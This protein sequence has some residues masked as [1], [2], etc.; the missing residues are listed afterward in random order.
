[1]GAVLF[2]FDMTLVDSS[3][4][5]T[6][7]MNG[8]AESRGL[9]L[10]TREEVLSTIGLPIEEAWR[11]LWGRYDPAWTEEYRAR[12]RGVEQSLLRSFPGT[13]SVLRSLRER[14]I[15]T[16]V[17]SN[18]RFAR[19]AVEATGLVPLADVVVGLEDVERPKP[20]PQSVL[21]ALDRL[22]V[23]PEAAAY[24]GDTDIDMATAR[25]A[26]TLGVG[27]TTGAF[28]R[29]GLLAAGASLV[30]DDLRELE[31]ALG[32]ASLEVPRVGS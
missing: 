20:D 16:G 3:H 25:A 21:L 10:L 4:A 8:L 7:C 2:D 18:R 19:V 15:R 17:V 5:I 27:M 9:R 13:V 26:G 23:P 11:V 14:D 6:H 22:G 29:A 31:G 12:F 1:M 32:L 28:D 24:V 30:L